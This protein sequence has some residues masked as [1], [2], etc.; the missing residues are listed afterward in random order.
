MLLY[1]TYVSWIPRN[2]KIFI[3]KP[4]IRVNSWIWTNSPYIWSLLVFWDRPFWVD[5]F[6]EKFWK[7]FMRWIRENPRIHRSFDFCDFSFKNSNLG[8]KLKFWDF[9]KFSQL[10]DIQNEILETFD[11]KSWKFW[12]VLPFRSHFFH[13]FT[14]LILDMFI[15]WQWRYNLMFRCL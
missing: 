15:P 14:D 2:L 1:V 4:K 6:C 3:F 12:N 8:L 7:S 10:F 11:P 5:F 13:E 9:S